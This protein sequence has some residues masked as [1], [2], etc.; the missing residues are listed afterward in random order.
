MP[1]KQQEVDAVDA[2]DGR[3]RA[4]VRAPNERFRGVEIGRGRRG[5]GEPVERV[6]DAAHEGVGAVGRRHGHQGLDF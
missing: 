5:G 1:R 6:G 3:E 2:L 4:P